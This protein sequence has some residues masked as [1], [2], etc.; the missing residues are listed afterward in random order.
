MDATIWVAIISV[1]ASAVSALASILAPLIV[2]SLKIKHQRKLWEQQFYDEHR[3]EAIEYFLKA[4]GAFVY[5][6]S[7]NNRK[8]L[9]ASAGEIYLYADP[10]LWGDIDTLLDFCGGSLSNCDEAQKIHAR[11][12][13]KL[14]DY[15]PRSKR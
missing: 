5:S 15:S 7:L 11:L 3:A 4:T 6:K 14:R 9:G 8:E 13:K 1:I 12:C 10:E 2:E